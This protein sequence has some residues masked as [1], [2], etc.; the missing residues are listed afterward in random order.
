MSKPWE[1]IV[2]RKLNRKLSRPIASFISKHSDI[3]P[4]QVT[5]I[6]TSVAILSSLLFLKGIVWV[7][8]ILV[9]LSSIMDGVDGDLAEIKGM[10][11]K[12]G[13]FL[14][15]MLDRYADAL[16]ILG[17]TYYASLT[18]EGVVTLLA[19]L[20]AIIGTF[21]V[22]YSRVRAQKIG[23][24]SFKTGL[25]QYLANRDVRLLVIAVG[26]II[27]MVF[28]TLIILAF[29]TN[30]TTLARIVEILIVKDIDGEKEQ[31]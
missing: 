18:K 23:I 13:E 1:G 27:G 30:L 28:E 4:N 26:S 20:L 7:A 17:M 25:S 22:S 19:G 10:A 14:D 24:E 15:A 8:G 6:S 5:I 3:T 29:I 16:I 21:M 2:S 12:K 31:G 11:T 9:Q